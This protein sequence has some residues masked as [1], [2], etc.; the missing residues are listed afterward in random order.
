MN[1]EDLKKMTKIY[2]MNIRWIS[3]SIMYQYGDKMLFGDNIKYLLLIPTARLF[4]ETSIHIN[5]KE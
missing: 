2:W 3:L 4:I 1:I 5:M